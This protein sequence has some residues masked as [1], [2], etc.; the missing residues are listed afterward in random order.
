MADRLAF[1]ANGTDVLKASVVLAA[2]RRQ[3]ALRARRHKAAR[4]ETYKHRGYDRRSA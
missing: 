1:A 3:E 4:G 2:G